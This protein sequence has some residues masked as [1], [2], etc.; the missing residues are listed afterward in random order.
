MYE[1]EILRP[2]D[3]KDEIA[4]FTTMFHELLSM[5][6]VPMQQEY[7]DFSNPDFFKEMTSIGEKYSKNAE[8]RKMNANRGSQ[9]FIYMNR[10]FF[11]LYNLMFDLNAQNIKINNI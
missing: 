3:S 5:F 7:F 4:F 9:H 1:L 6:A 2:D 8:L 10:T 11:G